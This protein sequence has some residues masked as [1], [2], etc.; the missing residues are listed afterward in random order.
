MRLTPP[1][2]WAWPAGR[3][4]TSTVKTNNLPDY[5]RIT[6]AELS[7][8]QLDN[9]S[10]RKFERRF[11]PLVLDAVGLVFGGY[12]LGA[13]LHHFAVIGPELFAI[14]FLGSSVLGLALALSSHHRMMRARPRSVHSAREMD[15]FII[16][17]VEASDHYELAYVDRT[18]GTYFKRVYVE[19]GG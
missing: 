19:R 3:F 4:L 7:G 2:S 9:A 17:D 15:V 10:A 16:Q 18:S 6:L 13:T 1:R 14:I 12:A 5:P 11:Y 8:L